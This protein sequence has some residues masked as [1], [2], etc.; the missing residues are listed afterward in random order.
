MNT[1]PQ[2]PQPK[3]KYK[4]ELTKNSGS[5]RVLLEEVDLWER[6]FLCPA[7][8]LESFTAFLEAREIKI[9]QTSIFSESKDIGLTYFLDIRNHPHTLEAG[10]L[11]QSFNGSLR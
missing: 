2:P 9:T 7:I 10:Q 8:S 5:P 11:V 4:I 1:E 6:G 3:L